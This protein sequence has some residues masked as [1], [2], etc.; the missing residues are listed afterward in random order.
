M[1]TAFAQLR[2]ILDLLHKDVC[3]FQGVL[4]NEGNKLAVLPEISME[5]VKLFVVAVNAHNFADDLCHTLIE[6]YA[7]QGNYSPPPS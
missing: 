1:V 5:K 3:E 4:S 2:S 6:G 7:K